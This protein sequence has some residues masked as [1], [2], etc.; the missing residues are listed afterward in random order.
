MTPKQER[1]C[2]EYIIDL[3]A[4]QAAIRAGYSKK[5]ANRI[6]S[7]NLSKLD[8]QNLISEL[9]KKATQRN[10]ITVDRV[11]EEYAAIAFLDPQDIFNNDGTLKPLSEI[12]E[13]ARRAISG[14]E[15]TEKNVGTRTDPF[16]VDVTKIKI[17]N[18]KG[19]LDSI[20]KYLAMFIDRVDHSSKDGTM[21][22]SVDPDEHAKAVAEATEQILR[23]YHGIDDKALFMGNHRLRSD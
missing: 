2:E 6:A 14:I 15:I 22:P 12:P 20:G 1:F 10:E 3:N 19:A 16:M 23:K 18:K 5:T 11:L 4:T 9:S 7:Q 21:S 17:E 8:I 13:Q